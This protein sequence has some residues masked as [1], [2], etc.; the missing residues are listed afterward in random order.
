MGLLISEL[1]GDELREHRGLIR[2]WLQEDLVPLAE[3]V[4]DRTDSDAGAQSHMS[5]IVMGLRTANVETEINL[6]LLHQ[7][8][9]DNEF[10][11]REPLV[12]LHKMQ[13]AIHDLAVW[14]HLTRVVDAHVEIDA[15]D[16]TTASHMGL[17]E[18]MENKY[19]AL[20]KYTVTSLL[21]YMCA[22]LAMESASDDDEDIEGDSDD[23]DN[24]D[25]DDDADGLIEKD[26]DD[27]DEEEEEDAGNESGEP[28][29][30]EEAK[31]VKEAVDS[32]SDNDEDAPPAKRARAEDSE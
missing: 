32:D 27:S 6:D 4:A 19:A 14:L 12:L 23:E 20:V 5:A 1:E 15:F 2:T 8:E 10:K 11:A 30:D 17:D 3:R 21:K 18:V 16:P 22:N 25:E 13:V 24:D 26:S 9:D 28:N 29:S 7:F 31:M